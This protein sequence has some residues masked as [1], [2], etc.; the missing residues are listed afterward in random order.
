[1]KHNRPKSRLIHSPVLFLVGLMLLSNLLVYLPF[2]FEDPSIIYRHYDGPFY[3]YIAKTFYIVPEDHPFS[4]G[5]PATYYSAHFPLYPILIRW[6]SLFT[7][8]NYPLAMIL[9]TLTCSMGAVILFYLLLVEWQLVKSPLWT[10]ALFCFVPARWLLQHTI[11]STEPLFFCLIFGAFLAYKKKKDLLVLLCSSL[12]CITRPPG[13]LL[14]AI[15][16][17]IYLRDRNWRAVLLIPLTLLSLA[18]LF[19]Y[20]YY[21]YGDFLAAF[22]VHTSLAF[23]SASSRQSSLNWL[24][25]EIYRFYAARPNFH[26]TELY[27]ILYVLNL[28]GILAL[29]KKKEFFIYSLFTF[30]FICFVFN[31]EITR[32]LLAVAPF[33]L[34]VG[35]DDVLSRRAV[36]FIVFPFYLYL[37][38]TFVWGFLP[39]AVCSPGAF[40]VLLEQIRSLPFPLRIRKQLIHRGDVVPE[41][42]SCVNGIC[43]SSGRIL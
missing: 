32:Y 29:W 39:L 19:T 22:R 7:L 16:G 31:Y 18:G 36:R 3:M 21:V 25:L 37:A 43:L 5:L 15:F 28:A 9:T 17:L 2:C 38:Y 30:L 14:T 26:S 23:V 8:G 6:M 42:I 40:Q 35:F 27:L 4:K 41:H 24:P 10:A 12:A 34:L 33:A 1:M 11:G 13:F 20:H